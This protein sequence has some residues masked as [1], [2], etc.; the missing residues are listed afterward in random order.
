LVSINRA[1]WEHLAP[2]LM[3]RRFR[4]VETLIATGVRLRAGFD[5]GGALWRPERHGACLVACDP[6]RQRSRSKAA[7]DKRMGSNVKSVAPITMPPNPGRSA[8]RMMRRWADEFDRL[9]EH[10]RV[11]KMSA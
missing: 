5:S 11:I 10:G 2:R 7:S 3:H 1:R 9:R 6:P 8:V 4:E